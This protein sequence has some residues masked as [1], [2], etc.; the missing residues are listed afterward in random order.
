MNGQD[1][2]P[3]VR[4]AGRVN[5]VCENQLAKTE[6]FKIHS[7]DETFIRALKAD[8]SKIRV[9]AV[10]LCCFPNVE[11]NRNATMACQSVIDLLSTNN[12]AP[13]H[14]IDPQP[15]SNAKQ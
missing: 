8:T 3:L 5:Q 2:K 6:T 9:R 12:E 13:I 10:Y 7:G 4:S 1:S 15:K 14:S 11:Q